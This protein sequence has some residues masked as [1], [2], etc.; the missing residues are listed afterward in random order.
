MRSGRKRKTFLAA[1]LFAAGMAPSFLAAETPEKGTVVLKA[2]SGEETGLKKIME[3]WAASELQRQEGKYG[4]HGWWLWGLTAIDLDNDGDPDLIPTHHGLPG[5]LILK[6]QFKETGK[7]SFTNITKELALDSRDISSAIG[8]KTL[9]LD[10]N[11]D[12]FLDLIGIRAPHYLNEGG[13][14]LIPKG[15]K[16]FNTLHAV[17]A[18]DVN[19]DGYPDIVENETVHILDPA[20]CSF[21]AQP[22]I[23]PWE[24]KIPKDILGMVQE[25]KKNVRFWGCWYETD[26]DLN[27]DDINDVVVCGIA[28]YNLNPV[29]RYFFADKE[30]NLTDKTAESGL[31]PEATPI[32][33]R[34]LNKDGAVDLLT[35][36]SATAGL[37]LNDGKGKFVLKPGKVTDFLKA[38]GPYLHRAYPVDFDSDGD[39][40][41]LL[42]NPRLGSAVIFENAGNGEFVELQ[43]ARGWDSDPVEICDLNDDGLPDVAIGGPGNSITLYI[44]ESKGG[45]FCNIYARMEKPNWAAAGAV[46][47]VFKA[48]EL[49]KDG[50]RA[51]LREKVRSDA[52]PVH[53]GLGEAKRFDL[54][55]TFPAAPGAAKRSLEIKGVEARPRLTVTPGGMTEE[56]V[57]A[58]ADP[59]PQFRPKPS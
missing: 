7:L 14:K 23:L 58:S 48:G 15:T 34:D 2:V 11:G 27:N 28:G 26:S 47:E 30:G 38:T 32:L 52:T 40:D 33:F 29:G 59:D 4:S 44:N 21:K 16:G 31:P 53:V 41:L 46:V 25:K 57:G 56:K 55:V 5:G 12:G 43:K 54:R 50:A 3:D 6:N 20:T 49:G 42:Y 19:G 37:Y 13:K 24:A 18:E 51:I 17:T 36:E 35:A 1:L 45:N 9:A 39:P 8:R 10:M 22:R